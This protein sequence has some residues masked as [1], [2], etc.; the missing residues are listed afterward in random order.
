MMSRTFGWDLPPGV[1]TSML[2]GNRPEDELA[3]MIA[4][5]W[6]PHCK[7]CGGFLSLNPDD[8]EDWEESI[9]CDGIPKKCVRRYDESEEVISILGEEYRDKT[10]VEWI[11]DCDEYH[12]SGPEPHKPHKEIKAAGL[13]EKRKCHNCGYINE[14]QEM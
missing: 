2:P 9:E 5:G 4:D 3:D 8:T 1:T 13:I 6:R 11:S 12:D 7:V 14:D 10:Y